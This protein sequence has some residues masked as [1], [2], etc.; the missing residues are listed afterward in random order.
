M[1]KNSEN[2]A[3]TMRSVFSNAEAL[4]RL[5]TL[6]RS[7]FSLLVAKHSRFASARVV[8]RC[9]PPAEAKKIRKTALKAKKVSENVS[10]T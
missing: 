4:E 6:A 8:S 1:G 2:R 9:W 5:F 7:F 10:R 3:L